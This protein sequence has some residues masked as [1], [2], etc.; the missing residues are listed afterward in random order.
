MRRN[1][2]N[3]MS[4]SPGCRL[5]AGCCLYLLLTS[6]FLT[7]IACHA[8]SKETSPSC[9]GREAEVGQEARQAVNAKGFGSVAPDH[10]TSHGI[11]LT[12][13]PSAAPKSA[14]AGYNIFR[15][16]SGPKCNG[17][18]KFRQLN[19]THS[20]ITGNTC[21]DYDVQPGH[22]YIYEAQTVGTN[23]KVSTMSNRATATLR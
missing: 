16:E 18:C 23:T 13:D 2:N 17:D 8:T 1:H 14:V 20:P 21:T 10:P 4:C 6:A 12:W 9:S 11:K 22:M 7:G 15:R 3:E 5:K 19:S